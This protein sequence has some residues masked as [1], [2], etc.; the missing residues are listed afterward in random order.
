MGP[1][2]WGTMIM[3]RANSHK[4]LQTSLQKSRDRKTTIHHT[5]THTFHPIFHLLESTQNHRGRKAHCVIHLINI[6]LV[7]ARLRLRSR[8]VSSFVSFNVKKKSIVIHRCAATEDFCIL[9]I[10]Q[11]DRY[12]NTYI[13]LLT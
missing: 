9:D 13:P 7:R 3:I 10:A 5:R 4:T 6:T 11:Q 12:D 2:Q 8:F 1:K